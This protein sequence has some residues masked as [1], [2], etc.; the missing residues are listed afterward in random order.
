M[1]RLLLLVLLA[2]CSF[3]QVRHPILFKTPKGN[4]EFGVST[5][6]TVDASGERTWRVSISRDAAECCVGPIDLGLLVNTGQTIPIHFGKDEYQSTVTSTIGDSPLKSFKVRLLEIWI[7]GSEAVERYTCIVAADA[8]CMDDALRAFS[9]E[10]LQAHQEREALFASGCLFM[11]EGRILLY[12]NSPRLIRGQKVLD[13][14][15]NPFNPDDEGG[16][17]IP[18]PG[19]ILA[20]GIRPGTM[21][22]HT[23]L[24]EVLTSEEIPVP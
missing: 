19:I 22:S 14:H 3:A 4:V 6:I 11:V 8:G 15:W 10:G 20:K 13:A 16:K 1:K 21:E 23:K 18:D 17:H 12:A 2:R 9:T 24:L 7:R 5:E